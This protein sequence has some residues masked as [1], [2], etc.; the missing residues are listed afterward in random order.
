MEKTEKLYH[1]QLS[2]KELQGARYAIIAG[3]PGRVLKTPNSWRLTG[4]TI[5][6]LR[7]VQGKKWS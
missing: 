5:P 2:E 6:G 3:D 4:N 1:I 7:I